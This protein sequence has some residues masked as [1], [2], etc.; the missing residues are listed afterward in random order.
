[1][2][3]LN[4]RLFENCGLSLFLVTN[5]SVRSNNGNKLM[6]KLCGGGGGGEDEKLK[7]NWSSLSTMYFSLSMHLKLSVYLPVL[8]HQ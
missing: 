4:D 8:M 1:M 6:D 7:S 5:Y 2:Y 3:F